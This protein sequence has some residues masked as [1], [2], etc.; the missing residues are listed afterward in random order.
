MVISGQVVAEAEDNESDNI[1][2]PEFGRFRA[3]EFRV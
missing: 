1:F 3:L 2:R